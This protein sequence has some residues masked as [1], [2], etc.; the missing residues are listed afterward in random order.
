MDES[1]RGGTGRDLDEAAFTTTAG[2]VGALAAPE[3][4][5]EPEE[6]ITVELR[7]P[8][9]KLRRHASQLMLGIGVVVSLMIGVI[10]YVGATPEGPVAAATPDAYAE[11]PEEEPQPPARSSRGRAP[12]RGSTGS[13]RGAYSAAGDVSDVF[14]RPREGESVA[15]WRRRVPFYCVDRYSGPR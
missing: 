9:S 8:V 4:D 5:R 12:A 14:C 7:E 2:G 3:L 13:G 11:E 1:T 10:V 15:E 6:P